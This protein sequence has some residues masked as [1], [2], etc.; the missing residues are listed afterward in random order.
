[1]KYILAI[2]FFLAGSPLLLAS[3]SSVYRASELKT[4]IAENC[5]QPLLMYPVDNCAIKIE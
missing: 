2:L 4:A 1:M 5:E 3:I